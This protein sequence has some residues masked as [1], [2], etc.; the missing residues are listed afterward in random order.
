MKVGIYC[1]T[2]SRL[3]TTD[4]VAYREHLNPEFV[5]QNPG[6]TKERLLASIRV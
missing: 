2:V 1:A 6:I 5:P 3:Y 4:G